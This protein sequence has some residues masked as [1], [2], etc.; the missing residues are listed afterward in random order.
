MRQRVSPSV[1][2]VLTFVD[3]LERA[4]SVRSSR[5]IVRLG[6][7]SSSSS[8]SAPLAGLPGRLALHASSA[9]HAAWLHACAALSGGLVST[10]GCASG[11][12]TLRRCR[13]G[14]NAHTAC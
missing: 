14:A 4:L 12:A 7:L 11:V 13:R 8:L 3:R 9:A 10:H 1:P 5:L 6:R 2:D